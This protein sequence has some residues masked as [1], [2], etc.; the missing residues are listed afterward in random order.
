MKFLS[1]FKKGIIKDKICLL[2]LDLNIDE[3]NPDDWRFRNSLP[4]LFFLLKH[5]TKIVIISHRRR[6][7]ASFLKSRIRSSKF[8]LKPFAD[9]FSQQIKQPVIFINHFNF[10][11]IKKQIRNS[12]NS[13]F[14]LENIR[15]LAG[16]EKNNKKLAKQLASLA[17]F[18]VNDA[19]SASHRAHASIVAITKYL[20][21]YAGFQIK[22][23]LNILKQ[24]RKNPKKPL[25]I[26]LGGAKISEKIDLLKYFWN[27]ADNILLGGGP[28]NTFFKAKN[29][30]IGNSLTEDA[31]IPFIKKIINS[32][33]IRLPIDTQIKDRRILD[34]GP[35]T[36]KRY[37]FI[38]KQSKTIIWN[39]PMGLF[40]KKGFEKGT[41]GIWQAIMNMKQNRQT[42]IIIGGGETIASF[43][44]FKSQNSKFK[45]H[46]NIFISTGGGAMLAYLAGK[47]M[48]GLTALH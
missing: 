4:T 13:V 44:K 35:E 48:P 37:A 34:I 43:Q 15:F 31:A 1:D 21:A 16:E 45:I 38:I 8:S 36:V 11:K 23:E 24:V 46:R 22:K 47:K 3:I 20:P 30:P 9:L 10:P 41:F 6:L 14:L 27:K 17:D 40:E 42:Q 5:K 19:F 39:G 33:K 28:A 2:R 26:I 32:P 12:K 7:N 29:W 18:Y 25:T